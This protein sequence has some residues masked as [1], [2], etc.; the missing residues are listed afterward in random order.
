MVFSDFFSILMS[1]SLQQD[2]FFS[3]TPQQLT[4]LFVSLKLFLNEIDAILPPQ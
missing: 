2:D 4:L 3:L 1:L